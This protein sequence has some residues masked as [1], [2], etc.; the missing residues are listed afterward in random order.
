MKKIVFLI[1]L[2]ITLTAC[3]TQG[4]LVDLIEQK[5]KKTEVVQ[6]NQ[7]VE[8]F[9]K[10]CKYALSQVD[11]ISL[12]NKDTFFNSIIEDYKEKSIIIKNP[13]QKNA[14]LIRQ[15]VN[16]VYDKMSNMID[17]VQGINGGEN[18]FFTNP[19]YEDGSGEKKKIPCIYNSRSYCK[20][21]FLDSKCYLELESKKNKITELLEELASALYDVEKKEFEKN[22]G[23]YMGGIEHCYPGL[24]GGCYTP[25]KKGAL[26]SVWGIIRQVLPDGS[27]M[28]LG[29]EPM[30]GYISNMI[31]L[32]TKKATDHVNGEP[33]SLPYV[34][35]IGT[36]TYT[37]VMGGSNTVHSFREVKFSPKSGKYLFFPKRRCP[38]DKE[39]NSLVQNGKW[40]GNKSCK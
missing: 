6:V 16:D 3:A 13:S 4:D 26:Y 35:Y 5:R 36:F 18:A 28:L 23:E 19:K 39:L 27:S 1:S 8:I 10:F 29:G 7:Q 22:Y 21:L 33:V 20:S 34:R 25:F 38:T 9:D 31:M 30:Y 32:R 12:E 17:L 24:G 37:T 11:G 15:I 40:S 2:C 14:I